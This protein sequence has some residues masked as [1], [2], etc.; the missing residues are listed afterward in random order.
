MTT[1]SDA[2]AGHLVRGVM[3]LAAVYAVR[4]CAVH[5]VPEGRPARLAPGPWMDG[6]DKP[7]HEGKYLR[8]WMASDDK[9][10][11]FWRGGKWH[12]GPFFDSPSD[13]QELPW[14]GAV[15]RADYSADEL[16][17]FEAA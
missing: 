10:F 12:A 14:R 1:S 17:A 6:S 16:A 7:E 4:P 9:A 13:H 8:H 11:S 5:P 15:V 3:P 2:V